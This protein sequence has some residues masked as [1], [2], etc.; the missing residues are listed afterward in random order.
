MVRQLAKYSIL[1]WL[2]WAACNTP[3]KPTLI[4]EADPNQSAVTIPPFNE[5]S[6][7]YF[8][9]EQV[10]FGPRVPG[11]K[12][13]YNTFVFLRNWLSKWCDTVYIQNGSAQTFDNKN[14]P[15]YNLIGSFNPSNKKRVLLCAHWDTRPF[16]DQDDSASNQPILGANDGGSGVGVLLEIA[17][18]ISENKLKNI[19]VDII[20]FDAED[21]GSGSV[22]DSYCLGSQYW[23]QNPHVPNYTADFGILLDMVGAKNGIFPVENFS[24]QFAPY[25][26]QKVW[27]AAGSLGYGESFP[28]YTRG[29]VTDDHYYVNKYTGIPIVDI[30]NYEA[31]DGG[32]FGYFWHT[33]DDNMESISKETL[34]KVGNTLLKVLYSE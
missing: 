18:V 19:G 10:N 3:Q 23:G 7:Y 2:V 17:R 5:D 21:W 20:F 4:D 8:I 22:E 11:S 26:V 16:A 1:L 30:I 32:S 14:I 15:I 31:K 33:H 24:N 25:I 12:P 29:Y 13:H 6:A 34:N 28:M 9:N 27:N